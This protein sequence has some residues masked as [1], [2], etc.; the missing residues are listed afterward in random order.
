MARQKKQ[1][2][3]VEGVL[4]PVASLAVI[5]GAVVHSV[6]ER[7][8]REA[9]AGPELGYQPPE[10]AGSARR[11]RARQARGSRTRPLAFSP[12]AATGSS[13]PMTSQGITGARADAVEMLTSDHR[14]MDQTFRQLQ[15]AATTD[16]VENQRHLAQH[17]IKLLSVHAAVEEH[18]L[19]PAMR[20]ALD[21]GD[22]VVEESLAE[23]G[24]LKRLLA[25]LDGKQPSEHGFLAGFEAVM[26]IVRRHA[27]D[28]EQ[29]LFPALRE[30]LG[31]ERLHELGDAMERARSVAPTRPHPHAPDRPP[32]NIVAGALAGLTDR[33]RHM[34]RDVRAC[35]TS[36]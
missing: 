16:A 33:A 26:D 19:Y 35:R 17:L 36:D 29:S 31:T 15:L 12:P 3:G 32:A 14:Q 11:C 5:T 7:R 20:S 9:D 2:G 6:L 25:D 22:R 34:V 27:A 1:G 21:D 18:V 28:E 8:R 24:E 10:P 13:A 23:H 30:R 4:A